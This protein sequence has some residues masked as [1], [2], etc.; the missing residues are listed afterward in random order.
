VL[1]NVTILAVG[2]L[3]G[4]AISVS[5]AQ[6]NLSKNGD[7]E[8]GTAAREPLGNL[9]LNSGFESSVTHWMP[10]DGWLVWSVYDCPEAL[11][12]KPEV[13]RDGLADSTMPKA[14]SARVTEEAYEGRYS[15]R[16]DK[17]YEAVHSAYVKVGAQGGPATASAWI[18]ATNPGAEA[19]M[20]IESAE[21]KGD[22]YG[23]A[24]G[25]F[26]KSFNVTA[27]WKRY[28]LEANLPAT[29]DGRYQVILYLPS[30]YGGDPNI[31]GDKFFQKVDF[32]PRADVGKVYVDAVQFEREAL[33]DYKPASDVEVGARFLDTE[34]WVFVQ[35]ETP[36]LEI[37]SGS[38]D[39][40][41]FKVRVED[42]W[43]KVVFEKT[44]ALA[45]GERRKNMEIPI[46][47]TGYFRAFVQAVGH[48]G[49]ASREIELP[50]GVVH[51]HPADGDFEESAFGGMFPVTRS[52][53]GSSWFKPGYHISMYEV[54]DRRIRTAKKIG[55]RW[56]K[57]LD[58][59]QFTTWVNTEPEKGAFQWG[60]PE[61]RLLKKHG[62]HIY[63][64]FM[65]V[66]PFAQREEYKDFHAGPPADMDAWEN[67][68]RKS[69]EHYRG[70]FEIRHWAAWTEPFSSFFWKGAAK[71]FV[72][73]T[74]R[75]K[76]AANSVGG[77][78][79]IGV[80]N[81]ASPFYRYQTRGMID[82]IIRG[83]ALNHGD[84]FTYH[85]PQAYGYEEG[86][87]MPE[88]MKPS[89]TEEI[90]TL[91][92]WIKDHGR[93]EMPIWN[94]EFRQWCESGYLD[95]ERFVIVGNAALPSTR[96]TV[97][98]TEDSVNWVVRAQV[99]SMAS[100]VSKLIVFG[101]GT[102]GWNYDLTSW[103]QM[104]EPDGRPK[105]WMLAYSA[106]AHMLEGARPA[107]EVKLHK[108]ARCYLFERGDETVAVVWGLFTDKEKLGGLTFAAGNCTVFDL[109]GN[110]AEDA[111]DGEN[112]VVPLEACPRYVVF[113]GA[114]PEKAAAALRDGKIQ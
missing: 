14:W 87:I 90:E 83:G 114:N 30:E 81:A 2:I 56:V 61:V 73:L 49:Q 84:I 6:E 101:L 7:L 16:L 99:V 15:C 17:D 36:T 107:H 77:N 26:E 89:W 70:D 24:T 63:G 4:F 54:D 25:R 10:L 21:R 74:R 45:D 33:T 100:G 88:E 38:A 85:R 9:L 111:G 62:F 50:F 32:R 28:F 58:L 11:L 40:G 42:L 66:P 96:K 108:R 105:P 92:E 113:P 41:A 60:D 31:G 3:C 80:V 69:L 75:T 55:M 12:R 76:Q 44:V 34:D 112:V 106:M 102:N 98:S 20:V 103:Q 53:P 29:G 82:G 47:G 57:C 51:A 19:V 52:G 46:S 64:K 59:I 13:Y 18:K 94:T 78:V 109:M 97:S 48:G 43:R 39:V 8:E 104:I 35:K 23:E 95:K 22:G 68:V 110:V 1:N 91:K 72:E 71:E 93:G 86:S 67:Y 27:D 5:C 37:E 79:K 65:Y